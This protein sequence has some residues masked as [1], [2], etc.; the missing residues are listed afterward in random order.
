MPPFSLCLQEPVASPVLIDDIKC[1]FLRYHLI[2]SSPRWL[3]IPTVTETGTE[4][5]L[6][7]LLSVVNFLFLCIAFTF[8]S[9]FHLNPVLHFSLSFFLSLLK[10]IV[11]VLQKFY[12]GGNGLLQKRKDVLYVLKLNKKK[13]CM[14]NAS[15]NFRVFK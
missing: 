7:C 15:I 3:G 6:L 12:F 1:Y 14:L 9:G 13:H 10:L 5:A 8:M 2:L 11:R 4:I